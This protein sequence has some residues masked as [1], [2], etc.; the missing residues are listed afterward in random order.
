MQ[1][2]EAQNKLQGI[3][4]VLEGIDRQL[5]TLSGQLPRPENQD[6]MFECDIPC[7]VA[8][9]ISG[10]IDFIREEDLERVIEGLRDAAELT[11]EELVRRFR[12]LQENDAGASQPEA[13]MN[14]AASSASS[15]GAKR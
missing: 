11:V 7:D 2:A 3:V 9:G 10:A 1:V 12:K 6:A 5:E 15:G 13:A 14:P 8:T 4:G